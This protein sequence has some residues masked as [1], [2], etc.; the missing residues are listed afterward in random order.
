[1]RAS[2]ILLV[3]LALTALSATTALACSCLR[4]KSAAEQYA[5]AET[6]FVGRA[7]GR[8]ILHR[9]GGAPIGATR[10]IVQKTLKGRVQR[11][12]RVVH[13][14]N[15]G[16]C[17]ISFRRGRTYLVIAYRSEGRWH[18]NSCSAPQFPRAEFERLAAR[19]GR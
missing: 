2:R 10:F 18:T 16:M 15:D 14:E 8:E 5:K 19:R 9:D 17:G 7:D 13:G 6:I 3:A 4:F 1:M 12:R 11:V